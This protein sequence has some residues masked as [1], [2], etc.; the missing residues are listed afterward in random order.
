MSP[1]NIKE[2]VLVAQ[3]EISPISDARGSED[4]KRLYS[5]DLSMR[6]SCFVS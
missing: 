1:D 2:A 6:T 5:Q 4:Y 3:K